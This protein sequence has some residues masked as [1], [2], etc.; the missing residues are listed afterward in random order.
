MFNFELKNFEHFIL[1][2]FFS[3]FSHITR[4]A[5]YQHPCANQ[6]GHLTNGTMTTLASQQKQ[7]LPL[8]QP[9][10]H[11]HNVWVPA[12]PYLTEEIPNWLFIY[13]RAPVELDH[14]LKVKIDHYFFYN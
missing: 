5:Q 9:S 3:I 1:N 12:N 13:S 6:Y 8:P 11:Q 14:Q 4:Q 7:S 2:L 10:F